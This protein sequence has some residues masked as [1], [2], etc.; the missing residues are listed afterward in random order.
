MIADVPGG[1]VLSGGLDSSLIV[2]HMAKL[3]S[4]PVQTFPIRFADEDQKF[5][6]GSDDSLYARDVADIF[7]C[8]HKE[9]TIKPDIVKI[10]PKM[11]WHLDEPLA[12][13]AAINTFLISKAAHDAGVTVLLNG[14]GGDEVFGGYRKHLACLIAEQYNRFIPQIVR[15][16]IIQAVRHIHVADAERGF[17]YLRWLRH[18]IGMADRD[19]T[20]RFMF[21]DMAS[22]HRKFTI[23]L[24]II[25]LECLMQIYQV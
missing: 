15:Q 20:L 12:D 14:M 2:A 3:T 16:M 25:K 21:A 22:F 6:A 19:A 24:K 1:A 10:L 4:R 8:N 17:K 18:F 9:I 7:H 13:P 11:I 5:E 23:F